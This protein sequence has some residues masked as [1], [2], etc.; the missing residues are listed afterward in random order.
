M[1]KRDGLKGGH[2]ILLNPASS[3][4][5]E[6]TRKQALLARS[7][8]PGGMQVGGG[9]T[10]ENAYSYLDAGASHVIVTSY[11]FQK[12]QFQEENLKKLKQAVGKQ[13]IVLDL[14][15]RKKGEDYYIVTDRWQT[16]TDVKIS[17]RILAGLSRDC[18]E[19]LVHGV[20]A[21][22]YTHL[23]H[24]GL[25]SENMYRYLAEFRAEIM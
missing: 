18:D 17:E 4:Y 19:F 6:Q 23:S 7:A 21:V 5:Y 16:F 12:G 11:V 14:S 9:I 8:Y 3:E 20:D 22:S 15:C 1:Y 13:R 24:P 25:K 2:I 10:S